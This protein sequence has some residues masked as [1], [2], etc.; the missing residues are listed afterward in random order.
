MYEHFP[1]DV[2]QGNVLA[3]SLL[4]SLTAIC[5]RMSANYLWF[6]NSTTKPFK[7]R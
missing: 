6:P 1:D 7:I 4:C 3:R 5:Y 2:T